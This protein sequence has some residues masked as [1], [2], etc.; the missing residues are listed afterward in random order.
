MSETLT[1]KQHRFCIEYLKDRVGKAAAIRAGYSPNG[2]AQT[3]Y[4]LLR[5]EKVKSFIERE[6]EGS[7]DRCRVTQDWIVDRLKA[8][9]EGA[10]TDGARI[11]A[12]ELLGKWKGMFVEKKEVTHSH[13]H[14]FFAELDLDEPEL[15]EG[16]ELVA[17]PAPD[18]D[19]SEPDD[20][21]TQ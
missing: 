3:A 8:E 21:E 9:A 1:P 2:A 13:S 7:L 19:D 10:E 11:R 14:T 6:N 15:I 18:D 16:G 17:L 4:E 5:M 20:C 12:L